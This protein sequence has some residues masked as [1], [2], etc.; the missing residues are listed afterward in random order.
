MVKIS[1]CSK[2]GEFESQGDSKGSGLGLFSVGFI[3]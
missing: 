1:S 2:Y 3:S